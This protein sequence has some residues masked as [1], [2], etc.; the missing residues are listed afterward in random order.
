MSFKSLRS[1]ACTI[2]VVTSI[3]CG[4]S[5]GA[6]NPDHLLAG[7]PTDTPPELAEPKTTEEERFI[8]RQKKEL[9]KQSQEIDDLKRQKFHDDY[10]RTRYPK[11]NPEGTP[12]RDGF[13]GY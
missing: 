7:G 4:S 1:L 8:E 11:E 12:S 2:L 5:K 6:G 13:G 10:L 9:E 3:G